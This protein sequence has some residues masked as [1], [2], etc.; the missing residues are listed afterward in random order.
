MLPRTYDREAHIWQD[1]KQLY[2]GGFSDAMT[3]ARAY[4]VLAIKCKCLELDQLEQ[5]LNYPLSDYT[6][7]KSLKSTEP[8]KNYIHLIAS[9]TKVELTRV[10]RRKSGGFARGT[11]RAKHQ[12]QKMVTT[13]LRMV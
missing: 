6:I 12:S 13:H 8:W 9:A 5:F 7:G 10:L 4:D 1:G 11:S 2:L 3:A